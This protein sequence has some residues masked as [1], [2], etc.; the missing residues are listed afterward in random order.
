MNLLEIKRY[1]NIPASGNT[2]GKVYIEF[3]ITGSGTFIYV[4][5]LCCFAGRNQSEWVSMTQAED[6]RNTVMP[7]TVRG[8]KQFVFVWDADADG[9]LV[10]TQTQFQFSFYLRDISCNLTTRRQTPNQQ[11]PGIRIP[12]PTY[13]V[14]QVPVFRPRIDDRDITVI[15]DRTPPIGVGRPSGPTGP[16][17]PTTPGSIAGN[18]VT[19]NNSIGTGIPLNRNQLRVNFDPY[20]SVPLE[21]SRP[22]TTSARR[23][24]PVSPYR[25]PGDQFVN[26]VTNTNISQTLDNAPNEVGRGVVTPAGILTIPMGNNVNVDPATSAPLSM[27]WQVRNSSTPSSPQRRVGSEEEVEFSSTSEFIDAFSNGEVDFPNSIDNGDPHPYS[28]KTNLATDDYGIDSKINN[29][30][31]QSILSEKDI[32]LSSAIKFSLTQV[33]KLP[34][35]KKTGFMAEFMDGLISCQPANLTLGDNLTITASFTNKHESIGVNASLIVYAVSP[36]S[37]VYEIDRTLYGYVDPDFSLSVAGSYDT[38]NLPESGIWSFYAVLFDS[39]NS[40]IDFA[41]QKVTFITSEQKRNINPRVKK[42]LTTTVRNT[43][44]INPFIPPIIIWSPTQTTTSLLFDLNSN[45]LSVTATSFDTNPLDMSLRNNSVEIT[46]HSGP[47]AQP[48][49]NNRGPIFDNTVGGIPHMSTGLTI[50]NRYTLLI[51]TTGVRSLFTLYFGGSI[52]LIAPLVQTVS[53]GINTWTATVTMPFGNHPYRLVLTGKDPDKI[54]ANATYYDFI[55]DQQGTAVVNI[56]APRNEYLQIFRQR[57]SS[58]DLQ[59][60]Q[61]T[62][63][64][65][66]NTGGV[67]NTLT[68][69]IGYSFEREYRHRISE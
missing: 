45:N 55:T 9:I 10:N 28:A 29:S 56:I 35:L 5:A 63:Y 3:E 49:P 12:P 62:T 41:E 21:G 47:I 67:L 58:F 33:T 8:K 34:V 19:T 1:I 13:R 69:A 20:V 57:A 32:A 14:P 6:S 25:N 42:T 40:S 38:S 24:D 68:P 36:S 15:V 26:T 31:S 44:N 22:P 7:V 43:Q 61:S 60:D 23:V 11:L 30:I 52:T 54:P 46:R 16:T 48:Y 27:S 18:T 66:A 2:R 50:G 64:S 39:K 4:P 17:G 53:T 51:T 59:P 37:I 65:R